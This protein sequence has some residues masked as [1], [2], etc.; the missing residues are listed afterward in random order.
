MRNSLKPI[1]SSLGQLV[2]SHI[3]FSKKNNYLPAISIC[4][5]NKYFIFSIQPSLRQHSVHYQRHLTSVSK[6]HLLSWIHLSEFLDSF[7]VLMSF[8][9]MFLLQSLDIILKL[10]STCIVFIPLTAFT[11]LTFLKSIFITLSLFFENKYGHCLW[12]VIRCW[13]FFWY[14]PHLKDVS[15]DTITQF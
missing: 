13:W 1:I 4:V 5:S 15:E 8:L 11:V 12:N 6:I 7:F 14:V 3:S 9:L 2:K 10:H